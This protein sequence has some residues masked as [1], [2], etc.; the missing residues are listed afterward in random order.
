MLVG[1]RMAVV[2][3]VRG[4][5]VQ[6]PCSESPQEQLRQGLRQAPSVMLSAKPDGGG[7]GKAVTRGMELW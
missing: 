7:D 1:P 2:D 4:A 6:S 3:V 5:G